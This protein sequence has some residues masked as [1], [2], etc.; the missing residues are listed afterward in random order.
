MTD[1]YFFS[2]VFQR[3]CSHRFTVRWQHIIKIIVQNVEGKGT[4]LIA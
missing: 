2:Y 1:S 3:L 4:I